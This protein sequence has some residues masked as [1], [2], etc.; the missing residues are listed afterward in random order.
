MAGALTSV[1]TKAWPRGGSILMLRT[2]ALA[3][4]DAGR[5]PPGFAGSMNARRVAPP[6][7]STR[8]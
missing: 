4:A 2:T 8:R 7:V 5:Q 1:A 6:S 3:F